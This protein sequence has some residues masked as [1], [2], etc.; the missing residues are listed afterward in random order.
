MGCTKKKKKKK[1]YYRRGQSYKTKC[2]SG[3]RGDGCQIHH[4]L[5]C[6]SMNA[7]ENGTACPDIT[8]DELQILQNALWNSDW[9][10]NDKHNLIGMP[11][12]AVHKKKDG[13]GTQ[14]LPSHNLDH[15]GG[16]SYNDDVTE[17]LN[18]NIIG[19]YRANEDKHAITVTSIEGNLKT[20]SDTYRQRIIDFGKRGD[21]YTG[22]AD[23]FEH[24]HEQDVKPYWFKPFSMAVKPSPRNPG[25][26]SSA[27]TG[28]F[29]KI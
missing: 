16:G 13:K 4:I 15:W 9:S 6:A 12:N 7:L 23:C 11:T 10:I 3:W 5:P 29:K 21:G 27:M 28:I 20:G 19:K 8:P 14:S 25:M 1:G 18:K 26:P 24:R 2:K 22:T 17:W